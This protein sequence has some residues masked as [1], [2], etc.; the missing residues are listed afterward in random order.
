MKTMKCN[1]LGG[2]KS[3]EVEFQAETW[4]AMKNQSMQHGKEMFGKG[5]ADHLEAM[6]EMQVKMQDPDSLQ[7]WMD[8]KEKEFDLLPEYD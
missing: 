3:C 8:E 1:Q 5:D 7:K 2:P 4:E 6:K